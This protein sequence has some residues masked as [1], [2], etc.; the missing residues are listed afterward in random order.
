ML[1]SSADTL[2]DYEVDVVEIRVTGNELKGII[3]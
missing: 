3:S 2:N 1:A